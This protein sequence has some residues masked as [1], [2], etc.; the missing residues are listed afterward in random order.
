MLTIIDTHITYV[1]YYSLS[2]CLPRASCDTLEQTAA[3][4]RSTSKA[5]Q[6]LPATHHGSGM[7][8]RSALG[9]VRKSSEARQM[10]TRRLND[11]PRCSRVRREQ[12]KT[13]KEG[14]GRRPGSRQRCQNP[15]RCAA[16]RKN[17]TRRA[18]TRSDWWSHQLSSEW[19]LSAVA[20]ERVDVAP[21]PQ[22]VGGRA[23]LEPPTDKKTKACA[24]DTQYVLR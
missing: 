5:C 9:C 23:A 14:G 8:D 18:R 2:R 15:G 24:R 11:I 13:K 17:H 1:I 3:Q 4:L 16:C 10:G 22:K 6:M 21:Y 19:T 7:D 12:G 20:Q